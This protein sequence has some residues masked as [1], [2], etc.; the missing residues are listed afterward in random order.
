MPARSHVPEKLT[1]MVEAL[2]TPYF[3]IAAMVVPGNDIFIGNDSTTA[4]RI[5][6][7][8]GKL[9]LPRPARRRAPCPHPTAARGRAL[10]LPR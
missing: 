4:D 10:A 3:T 1:V 2:L 7:T 8:A 5:F 9:A 6:N